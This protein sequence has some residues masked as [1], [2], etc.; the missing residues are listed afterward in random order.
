LYIQPNGTTGTTGRFMVTITD[1]LGGSFLAAVRVTSVSY[2]SLQPPAT[3][4]SPLLRPLENGRMALTFYGVPL[5]NYRIQRSGTLGVWTDVA[6]L[7]AGTDGRI[8]WIDPAPLPQAGF[9]R[10]GPP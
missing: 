8:Q 3:N 1:T 5:R 4:N 10:L 6:Y 2:E 7:P 9:Y